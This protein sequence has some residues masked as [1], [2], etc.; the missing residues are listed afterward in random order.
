MLA[1]MTSLASLGMVGV[2]LAGSFALALTIEKALR[3][4]ILHFMHLR[5]HDGRLTARS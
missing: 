2:A 3:G 1:F 4:R 5:A